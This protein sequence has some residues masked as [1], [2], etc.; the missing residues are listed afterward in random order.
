VNH[1]TIAV[2]VAL[3]GGLGAV[4]RYFFG[5]YAFRLMGP[6]FPWG[7]FGVNILGSFLIAVI[8]E[9]LTHRLGTSQ[10][11]RAFLVV[12]VMGGFT[13]FSSFSMDIVTL[14]DRK[15]QVIAALYAFGSLGLGVLAF[16]AGLHLTRQALA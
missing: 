11:L 9:V 3:G 4:G 2:F 7:T 8:V 10:E 15:Q 14:I 13:T 5:I 6:N 16:L 12:G 1:L